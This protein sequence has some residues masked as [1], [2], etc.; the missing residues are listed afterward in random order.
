MQPIGPPWGATYRVTFVLL[1]RPPWGAT[2]R[3]PLGCNLEGDFCAF[4][5]AP[6]SATYGVQPMGCNLWGATY[7]VTFVL[8]RRRP[9]VQPMGCNL[10]GATYRA[11]LLRVGFS[12]PA[13]QIDAA[14]VCGCAVLL[15]RTGRSKLRNV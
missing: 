13:D 12:T 15:I 1:R 8:L 3:A 14:L 5:E 10:W 4:K 6:P 7:R 2:Y 9:P 11:L